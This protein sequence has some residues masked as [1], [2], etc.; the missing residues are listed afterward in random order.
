MKL[1][2]LA[3]ATLGLMELT[4]GAANAA[5]FQGLGNDDPFS[6][7]TVLD[8]SPD[9]STV[10]GSI[11]SPF[12]PL[13]SGFLWTESTG[14]TS[15]SSPVTSISAD[16]SDFAVADI[17][18]A[19]VRPVFI[20][21]DGSV[22][23][24]ETGGSTDRGEPA[25][26][27]SFIVLPGVGDIG[28][29]PGGSRT[30]SPTGLS[31]DGST[32]IGTSGSDN[33]REGFV[34]R[35]DTGILAL[36]ELTGNFRDIP[37]DVSADGDAIVGEQAGSGLAFLWTADNGRVDIVPSGSSRGIDGLSANSVS[38]DG[39]TVLGSTSFDALFLPGQPSIPFIWTEAEGTREL[40]GYLTTDFGLD[41]T[42]WQLTGESFI[43]DD[44]LT[45]AGQGTN[46][47]G[48]PEA[49]IARLDMPGEPSQAVPEPGSLLG[50]ALLGGL[51]LKLKTRNAAS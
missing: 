9:G 44:G 15:V 37:L 12:S 2:A 51:G 48:E 22:V 50:L 4:A 28:D 26:T 45:I 18:Q 42:G 8:I 20:S 10:G 16:G 13:S 36:S 1:Y 35:E 23:V 31:T 40:Q 34:W 41:L 30:V 6:N 33:G 19:G 46:P 24:R 25:D 11:G 3:I 7:V 14:F 29:L 27:P 39:Q 21:G 5:S 38:A 49:W 47:D 17:F 43:S 32:I